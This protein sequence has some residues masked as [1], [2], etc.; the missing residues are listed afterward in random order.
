MGNVLIQIDELRSLVA[1]KLV[2]AKVSKQDADIIADIIADADARG[3]YSHGS[4]RVEHYINRINHGG[5]KLDVDLKLNETS[6]CSAVLDCEGGF[7]H[8]A[9]HFATS[10]AIK[11]VKEN[12]GMYIILLKNGSHCGTLSYYSQMALREGFISMGMVNANK[13]V[14]PY[15]AS[16]AYFGTNP[17]GFGFPGNKHRI[18]IDMATSEVAFGKIFVARD[19]GKEIPSS[20]GVDENGEPTTDPSKVKY[21]SPLGGYK[22]TALA[23]VVEGFTGFFSGVFGPTVAPMYEN[24]DKCRNITSMMFIMDAN[25]FGNKEAYFENVDKAFEDIKN[26]KP[27]PGVKEVFLPGENGDRNYANSLKNGV[28]LDEAV[29]AFLRS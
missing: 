20:W 23:S 12:G 7:G 24:I 17:M 22:G 1:K 18:L 25:I 21:V 28:S 6:K 14:V 10:E 2:E 11:K 13:G 15:G 26:L 4:M 9:M 19:A 27:A 16:D 29:V 5:L 8:I 3:V